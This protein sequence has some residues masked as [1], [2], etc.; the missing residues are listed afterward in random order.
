[1]A[2]MTGATGVDFGQIKKNIE[3]NKLQKQQM[4]AAQTALDYQK[5][6]NRTT[7]KSY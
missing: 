3:Q 7:R 5:K 2:I 1:M 6:T 4:D